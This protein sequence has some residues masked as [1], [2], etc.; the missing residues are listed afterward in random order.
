MYVPGLC[1]AQRKE[2]NMDNTAID[3]EEFEM[4]IRADE[5]AKVKQEIRERKLA[6]MV[7]KRRRI[8]IL[9]QY[10]VQR[11]MGFILT[12]GSIAV[13]S[14]GWTYDVY[15]QSKDGTMLLLTVPLG[16]Y[17]MFTKELCYNQ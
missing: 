3:M 7:E 9:K 17:M 14:A 11:I 6:R 13:V 16:L 4:M 5:R 15:T 8:C 2:L 12:A 10:A 1:G